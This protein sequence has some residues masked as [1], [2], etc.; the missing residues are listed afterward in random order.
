M[1]IFALIHGVGTT[2]TP[3]LSIGTYRLRH[4]VIV[5]RRWWHTPVILALGRQRQPD[6]YD[7]K[8]SLVYRMS[9]RTARATQ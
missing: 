1:F 8:A 2:V 6:L 4:T 5:S 7:F 9:S 3:T